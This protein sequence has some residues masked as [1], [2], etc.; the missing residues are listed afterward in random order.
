MATH[1]EDSDD[2]YIS[3]DYFENLYNQYVQMEKDSIEK[4]LAED[5]S[6]DYF[7]NLYNQY[8]E[9]EKGSIEK[10]LAE[11]RMEQSNKFNSENFISRNDVSTKDIN[12]NI[13]KSKNVWRKNTTLIVGDSLI[14]ALIDN[15]MGANVKVR[16]FPGAKIKDF[17]NY[18]V[19]L[20]ESRPSNI[21]LT[22][23]CRCDYFYFRNYFE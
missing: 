19:P 17:Y 20:L 12:H 15:R 7:D 18:L 9:M 14:S 8:V 4:L 22:A 1:D 11:V 21:I 23:G 2:E 6:P 3:S 5:I 13:H 10:Q 16:S